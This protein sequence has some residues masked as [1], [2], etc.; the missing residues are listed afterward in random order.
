[1]KNSDSSVEQA[2]L[3]Q[4]LQV[5]SDSI[6]E[7]RVALVTAFAAEGN[8]EAHR[9]THRLLWA[10]PWP[11]SVPVVPTDAAAARAIL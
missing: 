11:A 2:V 8:R 9:L 7:A 3:T 5:Y 1:M 4:R 10:M 6:P